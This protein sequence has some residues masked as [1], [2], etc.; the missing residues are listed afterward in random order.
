MGKTRRK[1][2][3]K[4]TRR[5]GKILGEGKFSIVVDP[6][7]P[8]KDGRDMS[9]YVSRVSKR[10]KWDDIASKDHPKLMKKLAELDPE[11]K[12]FYYPQ[13][14]EPGAMLKENKL[15]GVTYEK[16]KYSEIILRGNDVWNSLGRKNRSWQGFL[17]GKKLGKKTEFA[18]RSQEQLDHLKKAIDLLHDNDIVHHDLHG[19]NVIIADDGM[20]RIIDF[21]FATVDSPQSAI[22]LEKAYIDFSWPSLDVNWFKSR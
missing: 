12:Y 17:K 15:D 10:M 3:D 5:G 22:E 7:I 4:K 13:Y 19:Q 20:P 2:G 6:A 11:Q 1:R 8:C 9:K 14:C 18:G 21:G 16:K